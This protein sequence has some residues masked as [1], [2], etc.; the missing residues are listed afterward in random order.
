MMIWPRSAVLTRIRT[1]VPNREWRCCSSSRK[2]GAL[3]PSGVERGL[4]RVLAD[5]RSGGRRLAGGD[6]GLGLADREALGDDPLAGGALGVVVGQAEQGA[7]VALAD[8]LGPDGV[9]DLAGQVEQADQVRDGRAVEPEPAG[10]LLLGA[11]V[12]GQ[13][14][15]E[16]ARP[17]RAR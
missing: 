2:C 1:G 10:E 13:V 6:E 4:G 16:R 5:A 8:L 7:G 12:A 17:S 3:P 11:A 14:V 9:L 15:A